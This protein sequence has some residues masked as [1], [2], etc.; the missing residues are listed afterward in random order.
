LTHEQSESPDA[1][2][3]KIEDIQV[4]RKNNKPLSIDDFELLLADETSC[5]EL[6]G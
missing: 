5:E 3:D 2:L 4:A 6:K 1:L